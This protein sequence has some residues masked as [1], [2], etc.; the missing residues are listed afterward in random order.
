MSELFLCGVRVT[1]EELKLFG[2]QSISFLGFASLNIGLNF[3]NSWALKPVSV[4]VQSP[5]LPPAPPATPPASLN[6]ARTMLYQTTSE[7]PT[8]DS[9]PGFDLPVFYTMWHMVASVLGTCVIMSFKKPDTGYPSMMQLWHYKWQLLAI[10]VCTTANIGCNNASLTLISLFLNQVIKATGPLPTLVFSVLFEGKRYGLGLVLSCFAIVAGTVLSIP[11]SGSSDTSVAGVIVVIISTLAAS[12]KPVIMSLVMKGTPERPKLPPTVVL[13]YDTFLS[14][15]MMLVYWLISKEREN[16]V[17]YLSHRPLIG[18]GI[19]LGGAS[20]AFGFNIS[21]YFFVQYTSALT[22]TVASNGVKVINIVISALISHISG[23]RNWCG[24]AL[25]CLSLVVYAYFSYGSPG[26]GHG[27][28][29]KTKTGA[30][31]A[32]VS[33]D[34]IASGSCSVITHTTSGCCSSFSPNTLHHSTD[35]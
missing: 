6:V 10:A 20:M 21:S 8:N 27:H 12:L 32:K 3:Y 1:P 5:Q 18:I 14:F 22:T 15:W 23:A 2:L 35:P 9:G 33:I 24:V 17:D 11:M 26:H 31:L 19:I 28:S 7:Q 13:F 29:S 30:L 16:S 4:S 34:H 25:V